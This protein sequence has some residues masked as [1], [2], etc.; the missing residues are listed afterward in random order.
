MASLQDAFFRGQQTKYQEVEPNRFLPDSIKGSIDNTML[1]NALDSMSLWDPYTGQNIRPFS[2]TGAKQLFE[3]TPK[4]VAELARCRQYIGLKGLRQLIFDTADNPNLPLRCGW[5]YKK[6]PG[7]I[8]PEISQGALGTSKGPLDEKN[9]LD[10]IGKGVEWLWDLKSAEKRILTDVAREGKTGEFLTITDSLG[11][12]DYKGLMGYCTT[13]QKMIPVLP[14]GRPMYPNDPLLTCPPS[15]LIT[16]PKRVPPPSINNSLANFQQVAFRDLANCADT[17]KNPSLTRD[18]LLQA[19]KNNGC[20]IDGT[21]YTSLQNVDPGQQRWDNNLRSQLSFQAYQSKQGDNAITEKLFERGSSD[22]NAALREVTKL[23]AAAQTSSDPYIRIAAKDLCMSRGTFDTYNFCNE[24]SDSAPIQSV[25][26]QCIQQFWQGLDGKPA[27]EWYPRTRNLHPSLG[28][29]NTYGDYKAAVRRLREQTQSQD[30]IVQRKSMNSFYG[31]KVS[32]VG[33]SPSNIYSQETDDSA[34]CLGLGRP[35]GDRAIR[36]YNKTE[37]DQLKGNHY[38][39]GECIKRGGGSFSWDCRFLNM[40]IDTP[41]IFWLDAADSSTLV[42]D[43]KNALRQ[44]NDKS[45]NNRNLIQNSAWLRPNY[46]RTG[47][48]AGIE[49]QG[50][51]QFFDIPNAY[52]MLRNQFTVFIVERRKRANDNWIMLGTGGSYSDNLHLGYRTSNVATMAFWANDVDFNVAPFAGTN[53]PARI[54]CFM[55]PAGQKQVFVDGRQVAAGR[56]SSDPL[57]GWTGANIGSR[58]QGIIYEV[59]IYNEALREDVRQRMEGYLAQKWGV[60]SLPDAHPFK[61]KSP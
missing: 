33:F 40:Q 31:V 19:I 37:C 9:P 42:I 14:D 12:G 35:S 49:F 17:G 51:G 24:I 50:G 53:E 57:R 10:Q 27:G 45:G 48:G 13:T 16:D 3:G 58:Y 52:A 46:V 23:Q 8:I 28:T 44:W 2:A 54:F 26:L 34:P 6:S 5:R 1:N 22:W 47:G 39:N 21:L 25:E 15:R 41:L 20:G 60:P 29:I 55:K 36:L 56:G 32:A 38:A 61:S 43:G 11:S 30:P 7:S 18:C 59:I 4:D